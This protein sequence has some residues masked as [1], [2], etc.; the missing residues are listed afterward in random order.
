MRSIIGFSGNVPRRLR[1]RAQAILGVMSLLVLSLGPSLTSAQAQTT[2]PPINLS[3]NPLTKDLESPIALQQLG[4]QLQTKMPG[5]YAFTQSSPTVTMS[6]G[7]ALATTL[8]AP[9][10][11][12]PK[13]GWPAVIMMHGWG[14]DRT[15]FNGIA[16]LF[17]SHGFVVLS[18]DARGF[19]QSGGQTGLG[20]KRDILDVYQL[21]EWLIQK[22]AVNSNE[23]GLT[24]ISYGAGRSILAAADDSLSTFNNP[25]L[26]G[27]NR[28][29][30]PPKVAAIAPIAGW[31][32]LNY[33]LFPNS[34]VK[35]SF[36]VGLYAVGARP[37]ANN[38]PPALSQWLV[39]GMTGVNTQDFSNGLQARSVTSA[40]QWTTLATTPMYAFQA[41]KDELFPAEQVTPLFEQAAEEPQSP[42]YNSTAAR[43]DRLYLGSFGHAGATFGADE[44]EYIFQQ[45]LY[46]MQAQLQG[47][48]TPLTN[49]GRVGIG[50]ETWAGSAAV[51]HFNS[52]P[53]P[54][55]KVS[56]Y[57]L[58]TSK[59]DSSPT[60]SS[61]PTILINNPTDGA[62]A[63]P[64][65]VPPL[66]LDS[67]TQSATLQGSPSQAKFYL[68]LQAS[69]HLEGEPFVT[70][71]LKSASS[72]AE[73]TARLYD[74]SPTTG[75]W[76]FV[77][78]GSDEATGLS[79][80]TPTKVTFNLYSANHRFAPGDELVLAVSPSDAPFFR[81]DPTT[82]SLIVGHD[83]T[84][85]SSVQLP[86]VSG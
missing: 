67:L 59:L 2:L 81:P 82:L 19:G 60:S 68:P 49:Q 17:A 26:F 80:L 72:R 28:G 37:T 48:Q 47:Q 66:P 41:W 4:T 45:I 54:T 76:T 74:Y 86:Q 61:L 56:T 6:D 13:G 34:V 16:P 3:S 63:D 23:I 25:N 46:F 15:E 9:T 21:M 32:N 50:P 58:T 35:F 73:V 39:E 1:K 57:Y 20:G 5:N 27:T 51:E 78:R 85:P 40:S 22:H 33:A 53:V 11:P 84:Q 8:Y 12:V 52:Y 64:N 77:T 75:T 14:G 10:G 44:G 7:V 18:F 71:Y 31:T 79:L 70:F 43:D 42:L 24:G 30:L 62:F 29:G 55:A 36:D 65:L 69:Y 83:N 38:Y